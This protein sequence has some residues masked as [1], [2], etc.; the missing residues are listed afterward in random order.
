MII[1]VSYFINYLRK[2]ITLTCDK[3][4]IIPKLTKFIFYGILIVFFMISWIF[5]LAYL[6]VRFYYLGNQGK[7]LFIRKH[8]KKILYSSLIM[9]PIGVPLVFCFYFIAWYKLSYKKEKN[10]SMENEIN[11]NVSK[12]NIV[13]VE[14]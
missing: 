7:H 11:Y 5:V 12:K 13:S 4:E 9:F 14:F 1:N 10:E 8:F 6:L 2:K 3:Y